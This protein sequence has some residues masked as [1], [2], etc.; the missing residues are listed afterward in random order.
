MKLLRNLARIAAI[1]TVAGPA[2]AQAQ[3]QDFTPAQRGQIET[4][5]RNYLIEHPEVLIESMRVLEKRQ[6]AAEAAGAKQAIAQ[7]MRELVSD[8]GSPVD[9]NAKGDVTIVEF[10]DF[11]CPVCKKAHAVVTD[12]VKADGNIRRVYKNWPILGPESEY[13][14]RAALAAR[15]Q[16]KYIPFHNALI[17]A[18]AKLTNDEVLR[19]A[20]KAGLD[21]QRLVKD[22]ERKEIQDDILKSFALAEELKINGTPSYIIGDQLVKGARDAAGFRTF[23]ATARK[24]G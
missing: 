20:A 2:L 5:I 11:R 13:A 9:G 7:L 8:P 17:T 18:D 22:M 12:I 3:A 6:E 21:R 19:I 14:A 15:Y 16:D 23:V 1:C 4:I 24:K 10:F